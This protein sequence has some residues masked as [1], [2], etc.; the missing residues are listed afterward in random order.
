MPPLDLNHRFGENVRFTRQDA[1]LLQRELAERCDLHRTY[2]CSI[3]RG[4]RNI[5]LEVVEKIA[6]ALGVDPLV[7]LQE[8]QQDPPLVD[9][10]GF[11]DLLDQEK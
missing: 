3:E 10:G 6:A 9:D 2:I 8:H 7:L 1:G 5:T 4:Q 11:A